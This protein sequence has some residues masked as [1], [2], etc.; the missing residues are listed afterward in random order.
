MALLP[1]R[2]TGFG[3]LQVRP[4][5]HDVSASRDGRRVGRDGLAVASVALPGVCRATWMQ[6]AQPVLPLAR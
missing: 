3:S 5:R 4:V 2:Q 1:S 6:P